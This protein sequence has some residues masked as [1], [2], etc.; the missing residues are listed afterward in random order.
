MTERDAEAVGP[1]GEH[2]RRRRAA[3]TGS[4]APASGAPVSGS[5]ERVR[6]AGVEAAVAAGLAPSGEAAG[7]LSDDDLQ[8]LDEAF[9]TY[10]PVGFEPATLD[11]EAPL[12]WP[13]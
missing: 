1:A 2:R 10:E 9:P 6:I 12:G 5:T 8:A 11:P 7:V 3:T 13:G 4:G